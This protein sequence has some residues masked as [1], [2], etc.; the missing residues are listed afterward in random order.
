MRRVVLDRPPEH[1]HLSGYKTG[2]PHSLHY[3]RSV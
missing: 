2:L 3:A 1:T